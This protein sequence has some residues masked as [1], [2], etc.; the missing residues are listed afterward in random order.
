MVHQLEC[1]R[2]IRG[3]GDAAV[4][5]FYFRQELRN[6][7]V[8]AELTREFVPDMNLRA[9][10]VYTSRIA[11]L[12]F[13]VTPAR[14]QSLDEISVGHAEHAAE[15]PVETHAQAEVRTVFLRQLAAQMTTDLVEHPTEIIEPAH[16][17]AW[18]TEGWVDH[19]KDLFF[20]SGW[21]TPCPCRHLSDTF[22][23]VDH[24]AHQRPRR[25]LELECYKAVMEHAKPE[26]R[27][28]LQENQRTWL[29]LR[30]AGSKEFAVTGAKSERTTRKLQYLTDATES[31]VGELESQLKSLP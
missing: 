30:D 31:R 21:S 1:R 23:E 10:Q 18:A 8:P 22:T 29:P 14:G 9:I 28:E 3:F 25:V 6:A 19:T 5:R 20:T 16:S 12:D 7:I 26:G 15:Q 17:L 2:E 4:L 24:C 11:P 27:E 13:L